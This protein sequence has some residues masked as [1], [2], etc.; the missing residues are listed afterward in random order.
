M[1][2]FGENIEIPREDDLF[3]LVESKNSEEQKPRLFM[4]IGT[5]DFMYEDNL[6][7]KSKIEELD[8]DYTYTEDAGTHSWDFWDDKIQGALEWMFEK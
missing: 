2:V 7:L 4:A 3:S 6:R 1:P 8:Y 5:E